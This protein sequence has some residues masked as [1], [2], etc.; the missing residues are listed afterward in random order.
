M[1]ILA[2]FKSK[3]CLDDIVPRLSSPWSS[4]EGNPA[5]AQGRSAS[6]PEER[7]PPK[8]VNEMRHARSYPGSKTEET[9][10]NYL[11]WQWKENELESII[12]HYLENKLT[13]QIHE[14]DQ[15][16]WYLCDMSRD[17]SKGERSSK[18]AGFKTIIFKHASG[19][20]HRIRNDWN[21]KR[22]FS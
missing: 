11:F 2:G 3:R 6:L 21:M 16:N 13:E 15:T 19:M 14:K 17:D 5:D 9:K 20:S 12:D 8:M 10:I 18:P 4:K 1:P 22:V 7:R